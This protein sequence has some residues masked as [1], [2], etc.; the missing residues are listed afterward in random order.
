MHV[1]EEIWNDDN[2]TEIRMRNLQCY[3][4]TPERHFFPTEESKSDYHTVLQAVQENGGALQWASDELQN[5]K[6]IVFEAIKTFPLA[7]YFASDDLK[8]DLDI[9]KAALERSDKITSTAKI[10][11]YFSRNIRGN[12][13]LILTYATHHFIFSKTSI[14]I[15]SDKEFILNLL[16]DHPEFILYIYR[17]LKTDEEFLE[18]AF[19]TNPETLIILW[20]KRVRSSELHYWLEQRNHNL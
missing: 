18:K 11:G 14:E 8:D 6:D 16:Q 2:L 4:Q 3:I 5:N 17:S 12:K 10:F 19:E 15:K 1:R 7:V 9:A 13:E 20:M